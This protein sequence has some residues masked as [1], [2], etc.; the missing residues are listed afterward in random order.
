LLTEAVGRWLIKNQDARFIVEL[1]LREAYD[2][3]RADLRARLKEIG[4]QVEAEGIESGYDDWEG[5]DG[6]LKEVTCW[7]AVWK[8]TQAVPQVVS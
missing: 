5:S 6:Q 1:P 3:E 4:L 2:Q 8:F 7:W